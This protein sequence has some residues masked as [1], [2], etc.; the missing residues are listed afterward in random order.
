MQTLIA[1]PLAHASF[2]PYG[3]VL[4]GNLAKGVFI[5][6]GTSERL[7][8]P[9]PDL[10]GVDGHP[11]LNLY[12]AAARPLPFVATELERHRLGSQ[13]FIPMLGVPFVVIVALGDPAQSHAV[14]LADTIA[15]FRVD[16]SCGVTFRPGTWHHPL[17]AQ[18]S[19]DFVVLE[20]RGVTVDCEVHTLATP[21]QIV[22]G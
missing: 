7:A 2:A 6:G 19:G 20:R 5:N 21:I 1:R 17:L 8:L 15:A 14:P 18:R 4:G 10:T 13:S 3:D 16:G 9:D 12:R 22:S 11:A